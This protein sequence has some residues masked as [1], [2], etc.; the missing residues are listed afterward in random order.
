MTIIRKGSSTPTE[1]RKINGR[2]IQHNV[3]NFD[4]IHVLSASGEIGPANN[5]TRC[6]ESSKR[7][8]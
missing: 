4:E 8:I 3:E 7:F 5:T 1:M 6:S 2:Q